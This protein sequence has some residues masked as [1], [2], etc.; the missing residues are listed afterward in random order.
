MASRTAYSTWTPQKPTL[1]D[2]HY[3]RNRSTLDIGVLGYIGIVQHKEHSPEVLSI[4]PGTP[5]ITQS[6]IKIPSHMTSRY[7]EHKLSWADPERVADLLLLRAAFCSLSLS[8]VPYTRRVVSDQFH[9]EGPQ[10]L[11]AAAQNLVAQICASLL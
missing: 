4:P 1:S 9:A 5:C 8:H 2:G 3:L 7:E 11:G 10:I 6:I